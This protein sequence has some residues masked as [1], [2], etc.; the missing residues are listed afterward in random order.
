M[1]IDLLTS[2]NIASP[3][4]CGPPRTAIP[5]GLRLPAINPHQRMPDIGNRR[6]QIIRG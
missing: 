6:H 4:G 3:W 5:T 1:K 2:E